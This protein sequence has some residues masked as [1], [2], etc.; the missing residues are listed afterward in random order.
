MGLPPTEEDAEPEENPT[1]II[2]EKLIPDKFVVIDISD[3]AI[4]SKIQSLPEN[5]VEGTHLD[6]KTMNRRLKIYRKQNDST[7]G[8]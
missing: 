1:K 8:D 2:E 4:I 7:T 3:E 5:Q 6:E